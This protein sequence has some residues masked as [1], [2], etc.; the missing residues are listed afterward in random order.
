MH[1]VTEA[2]SPLTREGMS[3]AQVHYRYN[4]DVLRHV[5][6]IRTPINGAEIVQFLTRSVLVPVGSNRDDSL[7]QQCT[8]WLETR[9]NNIADSSSGGG[10]A[11][12]V[13]SKYGRTFDLQFWQC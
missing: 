7:R 3:S 2:I 12:I 13:R 11:A 10:G 5:D 1:A 6:N 9:T 4:N 8:G